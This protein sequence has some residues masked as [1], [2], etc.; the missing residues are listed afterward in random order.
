M[1]R[2]IYY[3]NITDLFYI[4]FVSVYRHKLQCWGPAQIDDV[5]FEHID[6]FPEYQEQLV[7]TIKSFF[8]IYTFLFSFHFYDFPENII[9]IFSDNNPLRS[10]WDETHR[11]NLVCQILPLFNLI[12]TRGSIWCRH[13]CLMLHN[14]SAYYKWC[15]FQIDYI[16]FRMQNRKPVSISIAE[17][18]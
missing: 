16:G 18:F 2:S 7:R 4:I 8:L 14:S 12:F 1:H 9:Y 3:T 6:R 15:S 11:S 10:Y 5:P 13:L 17:A